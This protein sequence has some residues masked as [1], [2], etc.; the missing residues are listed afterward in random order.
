MFLINLSFVMGYSYIAIYMDSLGVAMAWIGVAEGVAEAS[1]YIM[2]LFS[3][4]LSDYFRRRKP[5]MVVGYSLIVYKN[6]FSNY[7]KYKTDS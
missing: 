1:S 5:L 4:M 7:F 3:G 6:I 2:K